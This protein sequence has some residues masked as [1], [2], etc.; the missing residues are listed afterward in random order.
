MMNTS[1]YSC[2]TPH[3]V[4]CTSPVR[5]HTSSRIILSRL[6]LIQVPGNEV[7][8]EVAFDRF[9]ET[10]ETRMIARVNDPHR[11]VSAQVQLRRR[12]AGSGLDRAEEESQVVGME[13]VLSSECL[14]SWFGQANNIKRTRGL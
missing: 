6:A 11:G 7:D 10:V 5:T 8:G 9:D 2:K 3:K 12:V 14:R 13:L 1:C 4:F